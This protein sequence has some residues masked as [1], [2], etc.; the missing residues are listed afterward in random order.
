MIPLKLNYEYEVKEELK[1]EFT[2]GNY[3]VNISGSEET[4][5]RIEI[6]ANVKYE[7]WVDKDIQNY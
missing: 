5:A 3:G 2:S 6:S 7:D 1:L 4:Q